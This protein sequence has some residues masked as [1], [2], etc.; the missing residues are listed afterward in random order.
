MFSC[1]LSG[2]IPDTGIAFVQLCHLLLSHMPLTTVTL[3]NNFCLAE[4]FDV[5][6]M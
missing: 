6:V 2:V 4:K 1:L 5:N 3:P